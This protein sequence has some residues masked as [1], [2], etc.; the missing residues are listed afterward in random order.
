[1]IALLY[2]NF[3]L[4]DLISLMEMDVKNLFR[5]FRKVQKSHLNAFQVAR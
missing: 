3:Y 5:D 2:Q 1:M 4:R